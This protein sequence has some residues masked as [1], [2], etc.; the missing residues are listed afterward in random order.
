MEEVLGFVISFRTAPSFPK[1]ELWFKSYGRFPLGL[2]QEEMDD[3]SF[4]FA[5]VPK[6]DYRSIRRAILNME[7]F[8]ATQQKAH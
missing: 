2:F 3:G 1:W 6:E 5:D 7:E 4:V 8:N